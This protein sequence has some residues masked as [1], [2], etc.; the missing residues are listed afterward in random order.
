MLLMVLLVA[1]AS[2]AAHA[3][4][5]EALRIGAR[6][7]VRPDSI[8]FE[9]DADLTRWQAL[10]RT[11]SAKAIAAFQDAKLGARDAWQFS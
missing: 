4:G 6:A 5:A 2:S 11:G 3:D 7:H 10:K 1:L 8:W 9:N